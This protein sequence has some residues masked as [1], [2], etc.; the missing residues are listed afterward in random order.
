MKKEIV[1]AL[2]AIG[3]VG[4]GAAVYGH[5]NRAAFFLEDETTRIEGVV[6]EF[7]F[8]NPHARIYLDVTRE[9]GDVEEWMAE[10]SSRNVLI[11]RGWSEDTI[12]PGMELIV[13]GGR[14]R[15]GSNSVSWGSLTKADGSEVRP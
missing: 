10:G 8:A 14:S 1:T 12:K 6:T 15:D 2:V 5:H 7:W 13:S 11:R 4:F 9:N 3:A